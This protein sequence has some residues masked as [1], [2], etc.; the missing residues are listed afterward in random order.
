M[1]RDY[2]PEHSMEYTHFRTEKNS[3]VRI[4]MAFFM[5]TVFAFVVYVFSLMQSPKDFIPGAI[6]SIEQGTTL[7]GA[8]TL[9]E[10][11]NIIR[12]A[13]LFQVLMQISEHH[14]IAGDYLFDEN[15][16]LLD[17][18]ERITVG[19]YGDVRIQVWLQEGLSNVQMADILSEKLPQFN[20]D[21]FLQDAE[22]LEGYLYPDTY[23]FFP[24]VETDEVIETL[25]DTFLEKITELSDDLLASEHSMEDIITMASII[26]KEATTDSAERAII[27][28]ILWKRIEIGMPLQVDAPFVYE[29]DKGSHDL[30]IADL[31]ED[32]L[33]NTYTNT[34][35]T[36][37]P[38]GNPSLGS[39]EAALK[40]ATTSYLF[41]LHGN[42]RQVHYAVDHNGHVNNKRNYLD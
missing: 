33:Y 17:V 12:S 35:L 19:Q 6:I 39:I 38:I 9:L 27:S 24:S 18:A 26:E 2:R 10:E 1:S 13:F 34:G 40:P 37:T 3:R 15:E 29:R 28:G 7:Q 14:V 8:A 5:V 4:A 11:N 21:I 16:T 30:T 32:S 20:R 25:H 31:R 42:D 23:Y 36:P 22:S 41:Y